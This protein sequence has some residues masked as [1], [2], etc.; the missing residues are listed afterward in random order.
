[1]TSST[2]GWLIFAALL[3]G[4]F[5]AVELVATALQTYETRPE[6]SETSLP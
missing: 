5:V 1:M 4:S 2:R 3:A 6:H